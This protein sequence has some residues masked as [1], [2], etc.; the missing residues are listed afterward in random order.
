ML[1]LITSAHQRCALNPVL[2]AL[3]THDCQPVHASDTVVKFA[4]DAAAVGLISNNDKT[5]LQEE[6]AKPDSLVFHYQ[7]HPQQADTGDCSGGVVV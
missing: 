3:L 7:S 2:F 6:G 1:F 4:D 5:A